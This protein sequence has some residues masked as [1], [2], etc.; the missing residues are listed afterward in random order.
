[1]SSCVCSPSA[2]FKKKAPASSKLLKGWA[3]LTWPMRRSRS[4]CSSDAPETRS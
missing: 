1:M 2:D 3:R 4:F